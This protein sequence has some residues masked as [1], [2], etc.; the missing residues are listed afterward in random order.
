MNALYINSKS[1]EISVVGSPKG[2][3]EIQNL[4]MKIGQ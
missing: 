4:F 2:D 3:E 1:K